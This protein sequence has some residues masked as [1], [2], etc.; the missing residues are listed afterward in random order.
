MR[1]LCFTALVGQPVSGW[2]WLAMVLSA[3]LAA[4]TAGLAT[5]SERASDSQPLL[6]AEGIAVSPDGSRWSVPVGSHAMYM[7]NARVVVSESGP[8]GER[9]SRLALAAD[10]REWLTRGIVPGER[11]RWGDMVT[12][13]LLDIHTLTLPNGAV[14]AGWSTQWRYVWPRDASFAAVA[15]AAS[16]HLVDAERIMIFLQS[17]QE[18]DGTFHARY[19]LDG[20]GPPDGRGKQPDGPGWVLW[21][22]AQIA[23]MAPSNESRRNL[24]ARL[25]PLIERATRRLLANVATRTGLPPPGSDYWEVKERVLT[26]GVAAPVLA[27]LSAAGSLY[28]AAGLDGQAEVANRAAS[29]LA[30]AIKHHFGPSRYPR[31]LGGTERDAAVT[32]LLPPFTRHQLPDVGEAWDLAQV[33]LRRPAG[34]LAPGDGWKDDGISWTPETALFALTAA[35]TGRD[36]AAAHW[37]DWL[38]DHRTR[39]GALPEKVLADGSPASV[40]PLV[41]TSALVVL[42]VRALELAGPGGREDG[43]PPAR[44]SDHLPA[45]A[46]TKIADRVSRPRLGRQTAGRSLGARSGTG[47]TPLGCR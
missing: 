3:V 41:W 23:D 38:E 1:T 6:H 22:A 36:V 33:E 19:L 12:A 21:A 44:P 34:G 16:G 26:L 7:R 8:Q 35:S 42:A 43:E 10:H 15:L 14:V 39:L 4:T 2:R 24:I 28:A 29:R 46:R 9:R 5:L 32:F 45:L 30:E 27:G 18:A 13:A 17:V 31:H 37:L 40:A 20:S 47:K 25:H 11:G